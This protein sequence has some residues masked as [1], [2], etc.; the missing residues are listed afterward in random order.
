MRSIL[1]E[2]SPGF[3]LVCIIS[4]LSFSQYKDIVKQVQMF[5]F[6]QKIIN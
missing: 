5:L 6:L 2:E 3:S 1:D 4:P